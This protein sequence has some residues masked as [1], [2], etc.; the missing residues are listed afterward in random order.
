[1]KVFELLSQKA[2][3]IYTIASH[4]SVE[5]AINLMTAENAGALIITESDHPVGI[6][7]ERDVFR[8]HIRDKNAAFSDIQLKD[9]MTNR[10]RAAEPEDDVN[11]VMSMM[12]KADMKHMP[13]IKDNKILGI[14]TLNDLIEHQIDALISELHQLK[15]Y[16]NDLH[17]AGQ[18]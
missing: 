6:F 3:P 17:D 15:D 14:L 16:I 2:R 8:A 18:D 1:M 13:V 12:I 10:W 7:A 9:A 11:V 4:Q 5:D